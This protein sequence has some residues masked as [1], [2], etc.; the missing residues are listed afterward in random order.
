MA[1]TQPA[2]RLHLD[3]RPRLRQ[4]TTVRRVAKPHSG[5]QEGT[6]YRKRRRGNRPTRRPGAR[7][8]M[9]ERHERLRPR[10]EDT[11]PKRPPW[12]SR[13]WETNIGTLTMPG[14]V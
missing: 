3:V 4:A 8:Y 6:S 14:P 10:V 2:R 13:H 12:D 11:W 5:R 7:A 9:P 1:Q